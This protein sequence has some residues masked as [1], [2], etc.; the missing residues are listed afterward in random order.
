MAEYQTQ[1]MLYFFKISNGQLVLCI[2]IIVGEHNCNIIW[3]FD[4][5]KHLNI[6]TFHFTVVPTTINVVTTDITF[7]FLFIEKININMFI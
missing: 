1:L 6:L 7:I 4:I 5:T 2:N 3:L